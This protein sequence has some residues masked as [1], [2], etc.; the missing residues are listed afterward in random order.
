LLWA[1]IAILIFFIS[2]NNYFLP[3]TYTL[4]DEAIIIDK[5]I[6][7]F[8]REWQIFRKYY[9]TGNGLVLSPFSKRNFLDNFRGLHI[10]LPK[11]RDKIISFIEGRFTRSEK[12]AE[13]ATPDSYNP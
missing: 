4:T 13:S 3:I 9:L 1:L 5:K 12:S 11:D 2:L 10:L 6:F 7:K 8:Q